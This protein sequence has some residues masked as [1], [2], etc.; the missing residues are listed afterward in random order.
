MS[1]K[2]LDIYRS[3]LKYSG[4]EADSD[5][6]ISAVI[7]GKKQPSLI[8]GVRMVLPTDHHLRTFM[9]NEKIVFHPFT[10]NI[11]RGESEVIQKLKLTINVK[12]NYTIATIGQSLLNLVA[13]PEFHSR[14]N[15]EQMEIMTCIKDCDEKA[16][17]NFIQVMING[18]KTKVDRLFTNIYLKRGGTIHGKRYSRV[19]IVSFPF[20]E[21]LT[22]GKVEK[23]RV[24][25]AD[26][27]KQL[28]KFIFPN[29]DEADC[30]N[31]GSNSQ[32][33]PF[34]DAL[35]KSS[36]NVASRLND[37]LLTYKDFIDNYEELM[38]DS[39]WIEAFENLDDLTSEIRKI[40][41]QY[42]NDGTISKPADLPNTP[43]PVP[44]PVQQPMQMQPQYQQPQQP[45]QQPQQPQQQVPRTSRGLSFSALT[46]AGPMMNPMVPVMPNPFMQQ[47]QPVYNAAMAAT[48]QPPAF[49]MPV[50]QPVYA[51]SQPF[52]GQDGN[53]YIQMSNGAVQCIGPAQQMNN[54][55]RV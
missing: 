21:D 10:E 37:I 36:C 41:V 2:L 34:L 1:T 52:V 47:Q 30:Y 43:M 22:N 4:L 16:V 5:G 23:I 55:Y 54:M 7:D 14:L 29:I 12:L 13:S 31:Y 53:M 28:F 39:D 17:V 19:G 51:V 49:A 26:T 46:N 40:P 27:Y 6:L 45:M 20:Y 32:V 33:A 24:K 11:L 25:D 18:S 42:G 9:K 3:I 38:F 48:V 50:Q 35:M 44:A 15:P 8:D